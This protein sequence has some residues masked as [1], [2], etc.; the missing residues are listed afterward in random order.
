MATTQIDL[1][2]GLKNHSQKDQMIKEIREW[3]VKTDPIP[4]S[5]SAGQ[6]PGKVE[7]WTSPVQDDNRLLV[8][9]DGCPP[10]HW[11]G[12]FVPIS[13]VPTRQ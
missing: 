8:K 13:F 5:F 12:I 6:K 3:L 11:G 9:Y 1:V 7:I 4:G 2:F 10:G